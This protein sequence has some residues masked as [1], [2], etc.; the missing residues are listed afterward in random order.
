MFVQLAIN[1]GGH[2]TSAALSINEKIIAAVEQERFDLSKHSRNFPIDAINNCLK[3]AKLKLINVNRIILTTDFK[4]AIR[5]FYLEPALKD[6]TM[7]KRVFEDS[8]IIKNY[9]DLENKVRDILNFKGEIVTFHHHL[10][11]IA[12]AYYPSGFNK[13]LVLSLDGVGQFETGMLASANNGKIRINKFNANYPH[14]LGLLY[15]AITF[16]LGWKHHCDEGIIMGLAPYGDPHKKIPK[17]KL[18]YIDIFRKII[19]I[20]K[21]LGFKINTKWIAYHEQRDVW[22][23]KK[24]ESFFG[25]KRKEKGVLMQ[26]HKDIAAALQMRIEEVVIETLKKVKKKTNLDKLCI[27]GGVGLNCSLNGKIHNSKIFKEIFIQPASGDAGLAIGG[28]YLGIRN[29]F[30]NK[31]QTK[32]RH[33]SYLGPSFSNKEIEKS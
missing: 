1:F 25:K 8:E 19:S 13:S 2:D 27:A 32:K 7:L 10:C 23:S 29:K 15:S 31:L 18:S 20:D 11:H 17:K 26:H 28:L 5:K 22:V 30:K 16:F 33:N 3:I 21:E 24:F 14:S 6:N 12:S 4:I 9:L